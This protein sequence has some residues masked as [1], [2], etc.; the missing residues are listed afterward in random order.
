MVLENGQIGRFFEQERATIVMEESF[1][2][3]LQKHS[4]HLHP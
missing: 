2:K 4:V 3:R 1:Q